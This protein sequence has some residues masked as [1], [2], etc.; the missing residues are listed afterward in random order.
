MYFD[1]QYPADKRDFY[2]LL[3]EQLALYAGRD[4]YSSRELGE[5]SRTPTTI[6]TLSWMRRSSSW[7]M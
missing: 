1:V 2:K 3:R 5:I 4:D 7:P 6:W